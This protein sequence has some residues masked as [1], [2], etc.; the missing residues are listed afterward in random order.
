MVLD[1]GPVLRPVLAAMHQVD[2]SIPATLDGNPTVDF[3]GSLLGAVATAIVILGLWWVLVALAMGL[4]VS[5]AFASRHAGWRR[6]CAA[7]ITLAAPALIFL[8][9]ALATGVM[10]GPIDAGDFTAKLVNSAI[11]VIR[12]K[13]I[14]IGL[15]AGLLA[16]ALVGISFVRARPVASS[17]GQATG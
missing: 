7:G 5:T 15:I 4:I 1:L 9:L 10:P 11:T 3:D 16:A 14:V 17:S 2:P 6:W 8:L 13:G 12:T